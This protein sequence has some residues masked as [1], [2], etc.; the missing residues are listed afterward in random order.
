METLRVELADRSYPILIDSGLIQKSESWDSCLPST[1]LLI[2]TDDNVAPLY[3][4]T[5]LDALGDRDV[6][7]VV[8]EAGEENKTFAAVQRV[9][10]AL[11]DTRLGRDGCLVSLG[12]GVVGDM[13]GFAA[14]CWQRGVDF[15]QIPTTLLAQVDASVGGKTGVNHPCGKNLIGAFHQPRVVIIDTAVLTTLPEREYTSAFAEI[16]KY[17]LIADVEFFEWIEK[18]L[19]ALLAQDEQTLAEV[20]KRCCALKARIVGRDE[21]ERGERALLNLGHTFGHA[22]EQATGFSEWLHGEAVAVGILLAADYS[23]RRGRLN[24]ADLERVRGLILRAGLPVEAPRISA[25]QMLELMYRDKKVLDRELRLVIPD[26][27][28]SAVL[29]GVNDDDLALS[30]LLADWFEA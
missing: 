10:D 28:G 15:I 17:G 23:N 3:L 12:G 7:T 24:D 4:Q 8:L 11:A 6:S 16:I 25:Q 21:T 1:R 18:Y 9:F 26:R 19:D 30:R 27:I 14:A 5:L 13:T 22:I 2:V 29:Q 20:V